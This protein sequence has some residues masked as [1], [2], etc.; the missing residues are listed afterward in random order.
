M[1]SKG[2]GLVKYTLFLASLLLIF[3]LYTQTHK[4]IVVS[5]DSMLPSLR[6]GWLISASQVI[7]PETGKVYLVEEPDSKIIAIKRLIGCPGDHVELVDG[8]TYVNDELFMEATGN[9]WDNME[10]T[11]GPDEYL[12]IGDNRGVS[13]DGRF[14]SRRLHLSEI[15]Y[16]LDYV[17]YP[18]MYFGPVIS[19]DEITPIVG[20]NTDAEASSSTP[21]ETEGLSG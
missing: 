19:V 4:V 9:S 12:F 13:Y 10:W 16:Q 2:W 1:K 14:W 17:I 18:F 20:D 5:G 11:L 8:A 6:D 21:I 7:Y 15:F 3:F